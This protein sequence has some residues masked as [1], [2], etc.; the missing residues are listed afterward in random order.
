M[1]VRRPKQP[2]CWTAELSKSLSGSM[3]FLVFDTDTDM[4]HPPWRNDPDTERSLDPT[5]KFLDLTLG[6]CKHLYL[7]KN[8]SAIK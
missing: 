4:F 7:E 2:F 6:K 8:A 1:Q 3:V 5:L